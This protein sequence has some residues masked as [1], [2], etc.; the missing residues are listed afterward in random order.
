MSNIPTNSW[1]ET[2]P[3][4]TRDVNLGDD[5]MREFKTQLRE[6]LAQD[7]KMDSSGQ[8]T[9]WGYHNKITLLVQTAITALTNAGIVYS[10]VVDGAVELHYTDDSGNEIQITSE[11]RLKVGT[12]ILDEADIAAD[13]YI[14]YDGD[15]FV[16]STIPSSFPSG[17]IIMWSGSI[18]TIPTGWYLCDGNNGTPNLTNRFIV[19]ANA[20]DGGVA[21]S[22]ITGSPLQS[23]DTGL[24]PAHTHTYTWKSTVGGDSSGGDSNQIN[25]ATYNTGSSGTGTKVI[26][27]FY[28]LAFIMKS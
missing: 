28:A 21:K 17:G 23:H 5:D 1:D 12:K 27:V 26:P 22:N 14:K 15:K 2:K 25:N 18:A 16:M 6:I 20:D 10:K 19:G 24:M 7:H 13:T 11:G 4:G 8:D 3:A 9:D